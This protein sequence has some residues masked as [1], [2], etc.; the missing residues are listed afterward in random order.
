MHTTSAKVKHSFLKDLLDFEAP[1]TQGSTLH[2]DCS[3]SGL[4]PSLNSSAATANGFCHRIECHQKSFQVGVCKPRPRS[5]LGSIYGPLGP[6]VWR[7]LQWSNQ[8]TPVAKSQISS[9]LCMFL[10]LNRCQN[11]SA[12]APL[13]SEVT[14]LKPDWCE[15]PCEQTTGRVGHG[16]MSALMSPQSKR[17]SY[18][19][20]VR[21]WRTHL[22]M[23]LSLIKCVQG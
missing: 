19:D 10:L 13:A 6:L 23:E 4:S 5:L 11:Q 17:F 2:W 21:L 8:E 3:D 20:C 9:S 18:L 7:G 22:C 15:I 1:S 14:T 12:T 16:K